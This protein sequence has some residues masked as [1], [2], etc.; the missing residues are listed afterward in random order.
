[1]TTHWQPWLRTVLGVRQEFYNGTDRSL[2]T[3]FKGVGSQTL[4]Q[5]KGSL[6]L[7]PWGHT[8]FYISAG[9]GFHS[10]D[11]RGVFQTLPLEGIPGLSH[12][13]PFMAKADGEEVGLRTTPFP[14]LSIQAALFQIDEAQI[15]AVALPERGR[16]VKT[17]RRTAILG[18]MG[19]Q[20]RAEVAEGRGVAGVIVA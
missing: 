7:G 20:R 17:A 12:H 9:R 15:V 18:D 2:I 10:D 8:E 6:I 13:T 16:G 14:G 19:P 1:M 4:F 5:P 3:G 11:V